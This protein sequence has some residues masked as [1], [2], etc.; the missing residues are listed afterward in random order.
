MLLVCSMSML[1]QTKAE[2]PACMWDT[3][4]MWSIAEQNI[5][6]DVNEAGLDFQS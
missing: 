4:C 1:T 3:S 5:I 2:L 6:W